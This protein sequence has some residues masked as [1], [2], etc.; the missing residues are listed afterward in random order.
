[1][2]QTVDDR[3]SNQQEVYHAN[4]A[5]RF[6]INDPYLHKFAMNT[7]VTPKQLRKEK[8]EVKRDVSPTKSIYELVKQEIQVP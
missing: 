1:M 2:S 7:S 3:R 6:I 8:A 4:V 5:P